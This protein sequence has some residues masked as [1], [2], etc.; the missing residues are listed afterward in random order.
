MFL[1]LVADHHT[2]KQALPLGGEPGAATE[3]ADV[4]QVRRVVRAASIRKFVNNKSDLVYLPTMFDALQELLPGLPA[5]EDALAAARAAFATFE[6]RNAVIYH[7]GNEPGRN[8]HDIVDD[9]LNGRMLHSDYAKYQWSRVHT[10]AGTSKRAL[11]DWLRG[12]E[13]LVRITEASL[14]QWIDDGSLPAPVPAS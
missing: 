8:A 3:H 1:E 7:Y 4:L 14:L 13:D 9:L 12:A 6:A 10:M 5:H 11:A 2:L